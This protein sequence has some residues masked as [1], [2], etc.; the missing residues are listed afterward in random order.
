MSADFVESDTNSTLIIP[1]RDQNGATITLTGFTVTLRWRYTSNG[2]MTEQA[3]MT[4]ANQTTSPGQCSYR[5]GAG[6][7]VAPNM[8]YDAVITENSSGRFV[9]Q[10]DEVR[11]NIRRKAE[12]AGPSSSPSASHSLSPSHS[13]SSSPSSSAS[14]SPS[15]SPSAS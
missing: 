15:A 8:Y 9:T 1:C 12:S 6:E 5:W 4:N 2:P 3:T 11:L 14:R 13:L 10:L 7:L